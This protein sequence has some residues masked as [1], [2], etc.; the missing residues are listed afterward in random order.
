MKK[1][2]TVA[3]F[4]VSI[5]SASF[6]HASI[7]ATA[8]GLS[9]YDGL[10]TFSNP[11]LASSTVVTNQYAAQ[12]ITFAGTN[13]GAIRANGCGVGSWNGYIGLS[14][15][16]LGT[17]GPTCSTNSV[18]DSFSMKFAG[19]VSAASFGLYMDDANTSFQFS[20][21]LNGVI[22]DTVTHATLGPQVYSTYLTFSDTTFD[23]IRFHE[24]G[25]QFGSYIFL[26]NVAFQNAAVP[27]PASIA[28][29]SF[30]LLGL[31]AIRR[32]ARKSA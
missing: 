32:K 24:N 18:N 28:L 9:T 31:G 14:G 5:F 25:S 17:F 15:D 8:T 29:F 7:F 10:V 11:S 21:L 12:G 26:D 20:S 2:A 1:L 4:A 6:A 19:P 13:G 30:G 16:T 27:E 3:Y 23:E 22:V